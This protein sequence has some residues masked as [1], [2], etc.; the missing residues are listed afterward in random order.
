MTDRLSSGQKVLPVYARACTLGAKTVPG[1]LSIT[2]AVS[3][4]PSSPW[5]SWSSTKP[6]LEANPVVGEL[7][8]AT[9]ASTNSNPV[10]R[11]PKI[12][13]ADARRVWVIRDWTDAGMPVGNN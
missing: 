3:C 9:G 11:T 2:S 13:S 12:V 7:K 8:A 1:P 6:R 10:A 4:G 5:W